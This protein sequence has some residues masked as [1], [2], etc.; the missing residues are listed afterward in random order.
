MTPL[1]R[2]LMSYSLDAVFAP[3]RPAW[4]RVDRKGRIAETGGKLDSY[5]LQDLRAGEPACER[6][7]FL[8]GLLPLGEKSM[9]LPL[10]RLTADCYADIHLIPDEH[11]DGGCVLLLTSNQ[12]AAERARAQQERNRLLLDYE[13]TGA[14]EPARVLRLLGVHSEQAE[15]DE[16]AA[17]DRDEASTA[18]LL[19]T[20]NILGFE[21]EGD[22][23]RCLG[24][25]PDRLARRFPQLAAPTVELGDLFPFLAHFLEEARAFWAAATEPGSHRSGFWTETDAEGAPCR[26]EAIAV[27]QGNQQLLLLAFVDERHGAIQGI[28]QAAREHGLAFEELTRAQ[29]ELEIARRDLEKRVAERTA[30]LVTANRQLEEEIAERRRAHDR[31]VAYQAQLRSLADQLTLVEQR[32]RRR[33]ATDLHDQIGQNLAVTKIQLGMLGRD[34]RPHGLGNRIDDLRTLVEGTIRDV[35]TLTFELAPP[36]LYELGLEAALDGLAERSGERHGLRVHFTDDGEPKPIDDNVRTILFQ[37]VREL[38]HNAAKYSRANRVELAVRREDPFIRVE[39]RDDGVGFDPAV[40]TTRQPQD[41]GFGLFNI[42]E[43]LE[44]LGGL[45]EIDASPGAGTRIVLRARLVSEPPTC[46][47]EG[48]RS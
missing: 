6:A 40:L 24:S 11:G 29:A 38:L 21:P 28:L 1:P 4:F 25:V 10:I 36:A 26:L 5:G 12:D 15:S 33:L 16:P 30:D 37:S 20:L 34:A 41:G 13:Q 22:V 9:L 44:Q 32:E 35:R 8:E 3:R 17:E 18:A 43:R 19:A 39:V 47:A 7:H 45:L 46:P 14:L 27:R 42:R 23:F 2:D 31:L 48:E